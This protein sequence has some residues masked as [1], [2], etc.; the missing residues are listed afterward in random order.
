MSGH[1]DE[2]MVGRLNGCG[3]PIGTIGRSGRCGEVGLCV[4]CWQKRNDEHLPTIKAER[5]ELRK[6]A[7][8]NLSLAGP[9]VKETGE[10]FTESSVAPEWMRK[11]R[12]DAQ[13]T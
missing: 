11:R 6:L 9:V 4:A 10:R 12:E 8:P 3:T 1:L 2:G 5:D 7:D 13:R